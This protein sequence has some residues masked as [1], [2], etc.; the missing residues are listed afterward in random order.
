MPLELDS[1]WKDGFGFFVLF[2]HM[3][4][5]FRDSATDESFLNNL[6]STTGIVKIDTHQT[7]THLYSFN[8]EP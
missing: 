2:L 1:G 7:A 4:Q 3:K 6:N 5:Q 8:L